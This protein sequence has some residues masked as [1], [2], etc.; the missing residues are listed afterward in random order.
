MATDKVVA[1][2]LASSILGG[3]LVNVQA[4][5]G[6]LQPESSRTRAYD[7]LIAELAN[8]RTASVVEVAIVVQLA[9]Q[10]VVCQ[11]ESL[12]ADTV[13]GPRRIV[14]R[15]RTVAIVMET[16]VDVEAIH[17]VSILQRVSFGTRAPE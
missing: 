7:F 5:G 1:F 10:I 14:A 16:L 6:V 15:V 8:V 3:A 13:I 9:A 2:P 12:W 17:L 11:M 4:T